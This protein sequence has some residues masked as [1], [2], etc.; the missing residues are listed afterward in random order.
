MRYLRL[1]C[2]LLVCCGFSATAQVPFTRDFWLN[3]ASLPVKINALLQDPR[4][5][6]WLGT[7]EGL[8]RFNG[9]VV[10]RIGAEN[11][12]QVSALAMYHNHVLIGNKNGTLDIVNENKIQPFAVTGDSIHTAISDIYTDGSGTIWLCTEG[13]GLFAVVN[14]I[15][16]AC[17][18]NDGLSDDYVYNLIVFPNKRIVVSTDQ[19]IN[20]VFFDNKKIKVNTFGTQNGLPDN[21]VRVV[22]PMPDNTAC[23]V[24]MQQ[25]GIAFYCR[26]SREVWKPLLDS[27]W[28]WG[29]VNDILP[30]GDGRAWVAT[31]EGYLLEL[32]TPDLDSVHIRSYHFPG[33]KINKLI[34]GKSGIIWCATNQGLTMLS[35]EYMMYLIVPEPYKLQRT[36]AM[37]CDDANNIWFSLNEQLYKYVPGPGNKA[38]LCATVPASITSLYTD[39]NGLLW[40]GTFGKGIYCR[41]AAGK[42]KHIESIPSLQNES[43]LDVAGT[44]GAIWV[45]GLN[46]VAELTH[47]RTIHEDL[48]L[49]KTHNKHSGAGS[50]YV[51]QVY[52]DHA[53]R[54][55]MATDGGGVSMYHNGKYQLF[56]ASHGLKSKVIYTITEDATGK[57]WASAL[58]DGLYWYDNDKWHLV[59]RTQGLRGVNIQTL[60][61]NGTGQV[62]AVNENGLDIW[63]PQSTQFRSYS[64]NQGLHIDT[65]ST[66]LKL[67]ARDK[68]GNIYIPFEHGFIMLKNISRNYDIRPGIS[69]QS[70]SVFFRPASMYNNTFTHDQNHISFRYEGINFANPDRLHYRYMLQGYNDSWI[71]TN[72]E[73]VTFPQLSP[74]KYTFRVQVS[75]NNVFDK[76]GEASYSFTI[77]Q[78]FWKRAWFITLAIMVIFGIVYIYISLR[79]RSLR[80]LSSL[81]RERMMFEYEHLKSQVNP[82]FLFN[83]LNT[84]A[85]LIEEDKDAAANYT[86]HLSDLYRNMLA[87]RNKDLV[88]LA[89][90]WEILENYIYIQKSRFGNALILDVDIPQHLMQNRKIVPLALQLLVENAIKHNVV[91]KS[92]PL[93]ISIKAADDAITIRNNVNPKISKEKGA[94]LGLVNIKKRYSLLTDKNIYFGISEKEYVVNLP[95]L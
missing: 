78:P 19:G 88:T 74:G 42:L 34:I 47:P 56:N 54:I 21:I 94:G 83:S 72:D 8:Y 7:D 92:Q 58:N 70:M 45:S 67:Y 62:V 23:W 59:G 2:L 73:A 53:G 33:K 71:V 75:L 36:G 90:E 28:R 18:S 30:L 76:D 13:D 64:K 27:A 44:T 80:K 82:H 60:A 38:I 68:K 6:L 52:P 37:A 65:T 15:A 50:D 39:G 86:T 25:G 48:R 40:I 46:G 32:T 91:S 4:G 5:Y 20:E 1:I 81:Q 31:D 24:G 57:I 17:N 3:D 89:E 66:V 26:K 84:L 11:V 61:A 63:Y 12:K 43:V 77:I 55:W 41:D 49:M 9:R 87:Y 69:I 14:H 79:E 35:N 51:Y 85:S 16:V 95:L 10:T 29:Q 22:K 93:T